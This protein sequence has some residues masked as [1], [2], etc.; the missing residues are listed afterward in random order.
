[1][2][3]ATDARMGPA[4]TGAPRAVPLKFVAGLRARSA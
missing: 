4:T 3:M 2:G 1:M